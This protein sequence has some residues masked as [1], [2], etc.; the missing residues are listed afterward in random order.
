[1]TSHATMHTPRLSRWYPVLAVVLLGL[2]LL[3]LW[4]ASQLLLVIFAAILFAI[5]VDGLAG[6]FAGRLPVSQGVARGIV[7][8]L[9][10]AALIAYLLLAGPRFGD[11]M[12]QLAERLPR[13]L[14]EQQERRRRR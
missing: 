5:L 8:I 14:P 7:V 4:H 6:L 11:Q 3:L 12:A 1:M 10:L 9:L 13:A 2:G